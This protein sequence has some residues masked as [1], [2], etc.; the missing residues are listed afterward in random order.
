MEERTLGGSGIALPVLGFGC[1][2][3]AQLMVGD[4]RD[5]QRQVVEHA[6]AE[7]ITYFDTAAGYGDGRSETNLG[8]TLKELGAHPKIST[9]VVLEDPDLSDVKGAVLRCFESS[10][11]RLQVGEVDALML[12]NRVAHSRGYKTAGSGCTF[13]LDDMFGAAGVAEA[14]R[15]IIASKRVTTVG[16]TAFGGEPTAVEEMIDS[17]LFGAINASYNMVNPSAGVRVPSGYSDADYECV[18][19][20][21]RDAGMGVM[22]IRVLS[23]GSLVR[24]YEAGSREDRLVRFANEHGIDV[25]SLAIRYALS[26]SGVTTAI[27]GITEPGHVDDAVAAATAGALD[28]SMIAEINELVLGGA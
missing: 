4:D 14:F 6:M 22:V 8:A 2:P 25:V 10:L 9:K 13:S 17:K 7:G 3:N 12:H 26:K 5:A 28:E 15:E 24:P 18:I 21:A 27:M 19:D 11:E 16:F 1:G 23:S 20:K